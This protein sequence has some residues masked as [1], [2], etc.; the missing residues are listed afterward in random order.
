MKGRLTEVQAQL[1]VM[2]EERDRKLIELNNSLTEMSTTYAPAHPAVVAMKATIEA[3]RQDPP[4]MNELK[5]EEAQLLAKLPNDGDA[6]RR[7]HT[8][9]RQAPNNPAAPEERTAEQRGEVQDRFEAALRRVEALRNRIDQAK[10]EERTADANF[11]HRYQVVHPAEYPLGPKSP[12]TLL[13]GVGGALLTILL[14]LL[15]AALA[16]F[17]SGIFFEPRRVRDHLKLPVLGEANA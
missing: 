12:V 2:T 7:V 13:V 9:S 4:A 3:T 16:D 17:A 14:I 6:P 11:N 8:N 10:I 15:A 5:S 1:R